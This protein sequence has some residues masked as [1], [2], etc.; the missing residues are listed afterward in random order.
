[1]NPQRLLVNMKIIRSTFLFLSG[2]LVY[3]F[4]YINQAK[5]QKVGKISYT[6]DASIGIPAGPYSFTQN[7]NTG[8]GFGGGISYE[9]Q[10]SV[11]IQLYGQYH[12]FGL[13]KKGVRNNSN[14]P[15]TVTGI[16][17]VT[18]ETFHIMLNFIYEY[19]LPQ[20]TPTPYISLG[21]G[22]FKAWRNDIVVQ[23]ADD[24]FIL[25]QNSGSTLGV[26]GAVGLRHAVSN[27]VSVKLEAKFVTGLFVDRRTQY[28]PISL[29][30]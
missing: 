25:D 23:T 21:S 11:M 27:A 20:V 22:F 12:R 14:S 28:V 19:K 17:D 30:V 2:L 1:M 29:G 24:E 15:Q 16:N 5:A 6:V 4:G 10:P 8:Y 3:T 13:D 7:W 9:V 26:N 18:A